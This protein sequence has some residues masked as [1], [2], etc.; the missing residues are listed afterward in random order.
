[1]KLFIISII[2]LIVISMF[3]AI[4]GK[5][6]KDVGCASIILLLLAIAGVFATFGMLVVNTLY[7]WLTSYFK[8]EITKFILFLIVTGIY[9]VLSVAI[10]LI[11]L[12]LSEKNNKKDKRDA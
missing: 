6:K 11:G 7:K 5:K 10:P 2:V 8:I 4:M 3:V 1:M 9:L 12:S